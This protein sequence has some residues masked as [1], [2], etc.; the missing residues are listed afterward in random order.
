[1]PQTPPSLLP[2]PP[3][4]TGTAG[5]QVT[6]FAGASLVVEIHGE[7][8]VF[9]APGLR[10]ELLR[11]IRRYGPQLALDRLGGRDL[12]RLPGRQR[13]ARDPAPGRR[14]FSRVATTLITS[15]SRTA[16]NR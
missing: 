11:V 5:L 2:H 4:G 7:I 15:P 3:D 9:S 8:D 13:A 6:T 12:H 10:D 14:H 16:P 1:M